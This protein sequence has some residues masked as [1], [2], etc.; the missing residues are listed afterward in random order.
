MRLMLLWITSVSFFPIKTFG[1]FDTLSQAL[2][3]NPNNYL[4][5]HT[6]YIVVD[7]RDKIPNEQYPYTPW[8][9]PVYM[10]VIYYNDKGMSWSGKDVG[11]VWHFIIRKPKNTSWDSAVSL[12]D[13]LFQATISL[14][15]PLY[16][17][18]I[19]SPIHLS[20]ITCS[21]NRPS[22]YSDQRPPFPGPR[23]HFTVLYCDHQ[24]PVRNIKGP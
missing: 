20:L 24:S 14:L 17:G 21:L 9:S 4:I 2:P 19:Y 22:P 16:L 7:M 6:L 3:E 12:S 23:C 1:E 15:R 8:E 5:Y 13:H 10:P 11:S 18:P